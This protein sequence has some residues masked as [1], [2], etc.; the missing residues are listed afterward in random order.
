[1]NKYGIMAAVVMGM[2]SAVTAQIPG[3]VDGGGRQTAS[4]NY[5]M[6]GS[7]GGIGDTSGGGGVMLKPGYVGQLTEV[8]NL[9]V[10]G[11]LSSVNE[12]GSSQLGG[13]AGLDDDTYLMIEVYM[14]MSQTCVPPIRPLV[15]ISS[16]SRTA[17]PRI[18]F[19]SSPPPIGCTGWSGPRT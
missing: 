9:T 2:T 3:T 14:P 17:P 4:A 12:G 16:R 6:D 5:T 7:M 8:T 10:N 11:T 19:A 18:R 15:S 1:M 13:V